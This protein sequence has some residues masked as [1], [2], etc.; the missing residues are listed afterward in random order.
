[1]TGTEQVR[2]YAEAD[3]SE[4][5]SSIVRCFQKTFPSLPAQAR[6][7]DL[8]CGTADIAI[9]IA[10][11]HAGFSIDAVDGSQTMLDY[12]VKAVAA[13]GLSSRVRLIRAVLPEISALPTA[14]YDIV[15][16]NSLLHH[17]HV[18]Q[19]LWKTV[20]TIARPR[21][22]VFI[23][24][25]RR[26]D[27]ERDARLLVSKYAASEPEIL[28]RDFYRSLHAAFTSEELREQVREAGLDL[29]VDATGDRHVIVS[30]LLRK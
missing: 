11:L 3:F 21:A 24:D 27:R 6:A 15:I 14:R 18:P 19:V 29:N 20:K 13:A 8:G 30:G 17:L 10:N 12:A 25:L 1:M 22:A 7:V 4:S 28:Q 2:A 5:H 9:R 26:P 16:S 23:A